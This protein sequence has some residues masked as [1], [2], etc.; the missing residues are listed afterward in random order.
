VEF[1]EVGLKYKDEVTASLNG[2][3]VRVEP[4]RIVALIGPTGS[5]KT[6]FVNLIPRFYDVTDGY[7]L[8]DEVDVREMDLVSL[9]RQIG[10]VLQ[11]SCCSPIRSVQH[12]L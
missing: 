7:V 4:N 12:C 1:R 5:G 10:I 9:R 6:S 8:V 3:S 2:I 11:T